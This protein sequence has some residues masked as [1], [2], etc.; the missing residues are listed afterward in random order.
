MW[1]AISASTRSRT[2][3]SRSIER[4]RE[5][6][7]ADIQL[8]H[9]VLKVGKTADSGRYEHEHDE[10][11]GAGSPSELRPGGDVPAAFNWLDHRRTGARRAASSRRW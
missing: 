9:R 6:I 10:R 1:M 11:Q 7:D 2:A 4:L 3:T 8:N 5:E